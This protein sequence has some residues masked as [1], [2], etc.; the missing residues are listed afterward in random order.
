VRVQEAKAALWADHR[1]T[2]IYQLQACRPEEKTRREVFRMLKLLLGNADANS[3]GT[4]AIITR[5][6]VLAEVHSERRHSIQVTVLKHR[7]ICIL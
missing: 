7:S 3:G 5:Q 4:R 2:R 1:A 6:S